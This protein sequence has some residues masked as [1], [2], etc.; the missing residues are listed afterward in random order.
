LTGTD[1]PT[2]F[3]VPGFSLQRELQAFVTAGLTPYQALVASTRNVARYFGTLH[4]SG[5][6]AVG[7]RADLV[8]LRGNPLQDI[9]QT[10]APA[11][12]MVNGRWI[13][14]AEIDE[15]LKRLVVQ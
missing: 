15:R 14:R 3:L 7:K 8:L 10:Q 5:T 11:G 12:V 13:A 6:V 9:A 4:E 2:L 1:A